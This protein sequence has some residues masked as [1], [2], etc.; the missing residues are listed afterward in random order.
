MH[1]TVCAFAEHAERHSVSECFS[2]RF[3]CFDVVYYI[4][5]SVPSAYHG[6][7]F[8]EVQGFSESRGE[9]V[10]SRSE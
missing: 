1:C 9:D 7:Y 6:Y 2:Y 4:P 10:G 8:Q 3:Y 5:E